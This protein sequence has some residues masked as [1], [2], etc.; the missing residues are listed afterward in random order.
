MIGSAMMSSLGRAARCCGTRWGRTACWQA[1]RG[2]AG[3]RVKCLLAVDVQAGFV[4]RHTAHVPGRVERLQGDYELVFATRFLN[5][6][7]SAFR[8]L[9]GWNRF[10]RGSRDVE[11]AFVP[12]GH[13]K[14]MDKTAYSCVTGRFLAMLRGCGVESVDVCGMDTEGCVAL[15]AVGLF[16]GG[17]RPVVLGDCCGSSG[18]A[19]FHEAGLL[20]IE[21][22][23]G[24]DQVRG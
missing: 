11:L 2:D 8:V 3:G 6:R 19:A 14:V 1:R 15:C 10:G 17:V 22:L 24:S 20:V 12:Q 16:E 18:G 9:M 4:N 23:I 5:A 7:G 13:V 21:R